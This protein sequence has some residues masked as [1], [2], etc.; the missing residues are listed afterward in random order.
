MNVLYVYY[1][2]ERVFILL[3]I[4]ITLISCN[5]FKY[6]VRK[7]ILLRTFILDKKSIIFIVHLS[8]ETYY[9]RTLKYTH[10]YERF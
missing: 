10:F 2:K 1:W 8:S 4:I 5:R 9:E 7:S 3:S 6:L